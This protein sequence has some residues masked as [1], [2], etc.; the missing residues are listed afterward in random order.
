M[1]IVCD[2]KGYVTGYATIGTLEGGFE[3]PDELAGKLDSTGL[4]GVRYDTQTQ[5]IYI[6]RKKEGEILRKRESEQLLSE[7][8]SR[9]QAECFSAVD[10]GLWVQSLEPGQFTV[11]KEWYQKWLDAPQTLEIPELPDFIK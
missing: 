6:D 9:R 5:D 4:A 8:R 7:I 10:R 1:V 11:L 2:S 3:V